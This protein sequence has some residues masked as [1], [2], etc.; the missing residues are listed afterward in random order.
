MKYYS[1]YFLCFI[2][3][4]AILF[5][6]FFDYDP[7]FIDLSQSFSKPSWLHPFGLDEDGKGLFTQII[8]GLKMSLGITFSVIFLS[9][10]MGL[11]LGTLAGYLESWTETIIMSFVDLVLAF[12]KFLMAL[13]LVAMLGSS[14]F[15]LIFALT[16]STWAGFARLTRAELKHLK[17]KEFVLQARALGASPFSLV[18]KHLWP[19]LMNVLCIHAVFQ[20]VAVLIAESGLSFLGLGVSLENPSLGSLLGQGRNYIFSAPH[21]IFFPSLV[22]FLFLLCLNNVGESLRYYLDPHK[23]E[24]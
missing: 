21:I 10:I 22:L 11:V 9:F 20:A 15:H 1:F 19:N 12:P 6:L 5:P 17:K 2:I 14:V 18:F 8:Y 16:F 7:Y 3:S 23:V 24:N 13:A 4:L